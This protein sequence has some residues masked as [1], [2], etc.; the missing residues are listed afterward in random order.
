[1]PVRHLPPSIK[2]LLTLRNP[3]LPPQTPLNKLGAVFRSTF[4][5]AQRKNALNGWLTLTASPDLG[6][7]KPAHTRLLGGTDLHAP[8]RQLPLLGRPSVQICDEDKSQ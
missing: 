2:Q 8:H 7:L 5:D 6:A 3:N 4:D 1:M